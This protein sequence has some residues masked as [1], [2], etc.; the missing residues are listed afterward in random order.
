M[1]RFVSN[2]FYRY[3]K[4][5]APNTDNL[6]IRIIIMQ[7]NIYYNYDCLNNRFDPPFCSNTNLDIQTFIPFKAL[8]NIAWCNYHRQWENIFVNNYGV[9]GSNSAL[10]FSCGNPIYNH[11]G[12]NKK[13][14][15]NSFVIEIDD[16]NLTFIIK[17]KWS[18]DEI[19]DNT[20]YHIKY[21]YAKCFDFKNGKI[22]YPAGYDLKKIP[23]FIE[24]Q[25][26]SILLNYCK[27]L[28]GI[29][30]K[31]NN[32]PILDFVRYP[33]CPNFNGLVPFIDNGKKYDF[34]NRINLFKDFCSYMKIKETK[35]LRKAFMKEP[36]TLLVYAMCYQIGFTDSNAI[37]FITSNDE[38]LEKFTG[39]RMGLRFSMA[40]REVYFYGTFFSYLNAY[41]CNL[42]DS[43]RLW[44][45]NA[46]TDKSQIIVAKR[47]MKFMLEEETDIIKDCG[48]YYLRNARNFP[49]PFHERILQEGF[50]REVHDQEMHLYKSSNPNERIDIQYSE[51][52]RELE[53]VISAS[54][55]SGSKKAVNQFKKT[56]AAASVMENGQMGDELKNLVNDEQNQAEV[57]DFKQELNMPELESSF[58]IARKLK[59]DDISYN[60]FYFILPKD[61]DELF[62][63]SENMRNCVGYLYRDKAVNK[64]C[65]I[66]V[67]MHKNKFAACIELHTH[68]DLRYE[69][70]QLKGPMNRSVIDEDLKA[71]VLW[72]QKNV[73]LKEYKPF[74]Y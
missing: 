57:N 34:R 63:I 53:T 67:M 47:F 38:F 45:Q 36:K 17:Q 22:F 20:E 48:E 27:Q 68:D 41:N 2:S 40:R 4:K 15:L 72:T 18:Y 69:I 3:I 12:H 56:K 46:L 51:A 55:I 23:N 14:N 32:A 65:T 66:A 49:V 31:R 71:V 37:Q 54:E 35:K 29:E 9:N 33:T 43:L 1:F 28:Y 25:L 5:N 50:T 39:G 11:L 7:M 21:V 26:D 10:Y 62:E 6:K 19:Q 8:S 52:E 60:D 58:D 64:K 59:K 74:M 24:K 44:V 30:I 61:T 16:Q 73:S 13:F 70:V 42:I